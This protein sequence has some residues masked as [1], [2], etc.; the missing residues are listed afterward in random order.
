MKR[1][2]RTNEYGQTY[3]AK[4][5]ETVEDVRS[6]LMNG[7]PDYYNWL[8]CYGFPELD[9]MLLPPEVKS[10]EPVFPYYVELFVVQP[11]K[12]RAAF[13]EVALQS[14]DDVIWLA[15]A[16]HQQRAVSDFE[17]GGHAAWLMFEQTARDVYG[18]E[19]ETG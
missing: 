14:V 11:R 1:S 16:L 10:G 12:R 5:L 19:E 4:T 3:I 13:G 18:K 6:M 15:K 8:I 7:M 17:H 2:D 9:P